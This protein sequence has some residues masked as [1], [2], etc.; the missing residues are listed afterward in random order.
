MEP[1]EACDSEKSSAPLSVN[2]DENAPVAVV[3]LVDYF[4]SAFTVW[5]DVTS[6]CRAAVVLAA[7]VLAA[8]VSAVA[9]LAAAVLAAAVFAVVVFAAVA[10]AVVVFAA[11]AFATVVFAAVVGLAVVVLAAVLGAAVRVVVRLAA[12]GRFAAGSSSVS[13][14][15]SVADR[16][17][18]SSRAEPFSP[19]VSDCAIA[20][21]GELSSVADALAPVAFVAEPFALD[22]F[23]AVDRADVVRVVAARGVLV[24]AAGLRAG[25]CAAAVESPSVTDS[26]TDSPTAAA[27]AGSAA[28]VAFFVV[29]LRTAGFFVAPGARAGVLRAGALFAG[30]AVAGVAGGLAGRSS[31]GP[32]PSTAASAR[33]PGTAPA[34]RADA[35]PTPVELAG[36][37]SIGSSG[38]VSVGSGSAEVTGQTY[39]ERGATARQRTRGERPA[40]W[41]KP[42][43][44]ITK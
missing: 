26:P 5:A 32:A 10:F 18:A 31:P 33:S 4:E 16:P 39:Q 21:D 37:G 38:T 29:E 11:V 2:R 14:V 27:S 19:V 7:V 43:W 24:R 22:V 15:G 25:F 30:A 28:S 13:G 9:V 35:S 17:V 36:R 20:T 42:E 41:E 40:G 1:D 34:P 44:R 12:A 6:A 8:V 3:A 23:A